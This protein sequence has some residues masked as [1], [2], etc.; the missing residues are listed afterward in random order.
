MN[1]SVRFHLFHLAPDGDDRWSGRREKA[2]ARGDDGPWA[3]FGG[4]LRALRRLRLRGELQAPVVV[5]VRGGVYPIEAPIEITAADNWPLTFEACPG[6]TPVVSG[7]RR[8]TGWRETRLKGRRLWVADLPEV[9]EGRWHFRE[10]YVNGRRAPRPRLPK[11]GFFRIQEVPGLELPAGWG[12]GGQDRFVSAPGDVREFA[13]LGDVEVVCLHFWIEER[14]P[15]ASFDPRTRLVTMA[16]P[17]HAPLVGTWGSRLADYYLD[18]VGEALG[19]PGEWYLDR[20]AGRLHYLPRRGERPGSTEVIAPRLLQLL[21]LTGTP[22]RGAHVEQVRFRGIT[23]AHTDWRHPSGDGAT[24][25]GASSEAAMASRGRRN[26]GPRAGFNQGDNDVPGVIT[27][28]GARHCAF[29]SCVVELAGWY[30]IEIGDACEGVRVVG[31]RLSDLGAG[32]IKVNGASARDREAAV[33]RTGGH[34]ITDNTITRLGRVFHAG[35]GVL[36]MHAARMTIAHNHIHDLFYS[37]ISVGWEWG[38]HRSNSHDNLIAFNHIHDLGQGLLSDMGG[39]Y[40]LGVQPG[41]V[42]RNNWVHDVRSAHY[43]GWCIYPDEGSS[44]LLIENNLCHDADRE[45]FHQ[46]YGRENM[47]VNN[48]FAFGGE[49]A[50]RVSRAEPHISAT[51]L[52]NIFL[53]AGRPMFAG[54]LA[55]RAAGRPVVRADLNLY[56]DISGGPPR[57]PGT[58]KRLHS[59]RA[60]RR[61]GHDLHGLAADPRFRD[62]ARRDFALAADSPARALGFKPLSL[63]TVGPRPAERRGPV[64]RLEP[65]AAGAAAPE[66]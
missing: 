4:A 33:H 44:H 54:V 56:W 14:S 37:G 34:V 41:T 9:R 38:Y 7:G 18:N 8:I 24:I 52:R 23:F 16:R 49:A 25:L 19:Q 21:A 30:G 22:E 31:C 36:S 46:H 57:F 10:L 29:E 61:A 65:P 60:W 66:T 32:G 2:G 48:I 55:G 26:R 59:W 28:S 47:V 43:G 58:G 5:R 53:S 62:P 51:F 15:I 11:E 3:T 13:N 35:I 50:A 27:L 39:I 40:T 45:P 42:I 12:G 1:D 17:S 6:E 63:R 64:A 20:V